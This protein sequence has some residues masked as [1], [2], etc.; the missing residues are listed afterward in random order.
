MVLYKI[1][2]M[3]AEYSTN[4]AVQD[5]SANYNIPEVVL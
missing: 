1:E 5:S 4:S 2:F 3:M